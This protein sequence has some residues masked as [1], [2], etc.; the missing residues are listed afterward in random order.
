MT[1]VGQ[2]DQVAVP[3][4]RQHVELVDAV[5]EVTRQE[6]ADGNAVRDDDVVLGSEC[7]SARRRNES[8]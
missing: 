8:K 7:V 5:P 2:H 6:D 1:V 3:R 4:I